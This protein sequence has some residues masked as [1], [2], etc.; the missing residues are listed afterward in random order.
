MTH[1]VICT[2]LPSGPGPFRVTGTRLR[3][4]AGILPPRI[5]A[6]STR[7]RW[8]PS[9]S[10][11]RAKTAAALGAEPA[12]RGTARAKR[13][14][15]APWRIAPSAGAA[16]TTAGAGKGA[17][18][19]AVAGAGSAA[20]ANPSGRKRGRTAATGRRGA[21]GCT[22]CGGAA[23][24]LA[25][26]NV[27]R[28]AAGVARS[29][30]GCAA[31]LRLGQFGGTAGGWPKYTRDTRCGAAPSNR[32]CAT[33]GGSGAGGLAP[34]TRDANTGASGAAKSTLG[35]KSRVAIMAGGWGGCN[36]ASRSA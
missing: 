34:T 29:G 1:S 2:F 11:T 13:A 33:A 10:C 12:R 5:S 6:S 22:L 30:L 23:A 36:G 18:V 28:V 4:K 27:G 17:V 19:G 14:G 25:G 24:K 35:G 32:G 9:M 3:K 20:P 31:G 8:L 21:G 15:H 16:A 26:R 7:S